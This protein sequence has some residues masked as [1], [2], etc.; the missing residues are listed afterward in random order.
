MF[1]SRTVFIVGA[2]ASH[3]AGLPVGSTLTS[4]IASLLNFDY[5]GFKLQRGDEQIHHFLKELTRGEEWRENK[6]FGSGRELAE[7]MELAPSIDTFLETHALNREFVLLGKL[8]IV[9]AISEAERSSKL[10]PMGGSFPMKSLS[11]T[12]YLHLARQLF[13]GIPA[14]QPAQAF[15][16]ISFVVFNYDRC[17]EVF[18]LQA[19]QVYFRITAGQA[20]EILASVPILHPYGS[21]GSIF[22][23][24]GN[25]APFGDNSFNLLDAAARIKTYSESAESTVQD[26]VSELVRD[27][28][29]LVFLGFA[30]HDQNMTLIDPKLTTEPGA[31]RV[32]ATTYGMSKSDQ[33]FVEDKISVMLT[34]APV[35]LD[36]HWLDTACLSCNDFFLNFWRS[37]TAPAHRDRR[38]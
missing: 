30:F 35:L 21:L 38:K 31:K 20:S 28:E 5:Q 15:D 3:E 17:L 1:Q 26:Q 27:A 23:G 10:A 33:A 22:R 2:G 14:N 36:D 6:F 18:L 7:A 4:N 11:E 19:L 37:L 8:G 9:K 29:T 24:Q 16:G 25:F 13:S 32:F 34:D 12:W